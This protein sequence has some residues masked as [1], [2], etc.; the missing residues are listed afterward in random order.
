MDFRKNPSAEFK[1][2]AK[3]S[4][5]E[6]REEIEALRDGIEYH[7]YL[8]YVKN[9]P[10]ISD[11][12]YDRLLQRL[13]ELEEAYPE[14]QTD[15]SPTRRV[16]AKPLSRLTMVRH[17]APML[18]LNAVR[19]EKEV[20]DFLDF[21]EQ[22]S[23][24]RVTYVAEPKFD[25]VSVEVV[26]ENGV[27]RYGTTRGDGDTGED[28]SAN[29]RTIHSVPLRLQRIDGLPRMLAVRGEVFMLKKGF[30]DLNR[31][32]LEKGEEPFANP[33]NATAGLLRQLNPRM[34][35][36]RPLDVRF[37]DVLRSEGYEASSHW[38]TLQ[39]FG[40]WGLKVDPQSGR[41]ASFADIRSCYQKLIEKRDE[42]DYEIDGMVIK[43]DDFKLRNK[44]GTRQRSPRWALAWKFPPR[45]EISRVENII[46]Q[47]GRTGIL[48]PVAF[49]EPVDVAG[50]TISRATLHNEAEIHRKDIRKGDRV[51]VARAGDVIPEVVERI[52]EPGKKRG[53][54]F[55]MPSHCPACGTIVRKEGAFYRCPAGLSCPAQLVGHIVHYASREAMNIEGL[56]EK[57]ARQLVG[58]GLV[59]DISDLYRLSVGDL[60]AL[61]G[62]AQKSASKLYNAIQ[63][64][65][66]AR[67][68]RFIYALGIRHVGQHLAQVLA[69]NFRTL[70]ALQKADR[71]KLN[72]ILE[73]GPE[74]AASIDDFFK[75][76]R[77]RE[78]L[79]RLADAGLK[80]EDV[81]KREGKM[82][83]EGKVF[84]FTG[85]LN[86][87][88]RSEASQLVQSLGG[89]V[90]ENVGR[91]TDFIVI[92]TD[93][94]TK[95]DAARKQ[96]VS[97][98]DEKAFEL[99]LEEYRSTQ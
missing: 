32:L 19:D 43:V 66:N 45:E 44:L 18:S 41:C 57:T 31:A 28:I 36:G 17:Q 50:V 23:G 95:L 21:V 92:G 71:Y 3:M 47:V 9:Q 56:S 35:A 48:T 61:E 15:D 80:I 99:M 70:D 25:G 91:E 51:R 33:R 42:L 4:K 74:T 46:V 26:Y 96:G 88:S 54:Q 53:K 75:Q 34:V 69:K 11:A 10:A 5:E 29:L 12:I 39:R 13:Q 7:N 93:P 40:R 14:F 79:K 82:P 1:D 73:V 64:S 76:D 24:D 84:V 68:D 60:L 85:K 67:L 2:I 30:Q 38:N 86:N 16:G 37:Y 87:Y 58:K 77:N 65:K 97:I 8:Y 89:R 55:T 72:K 20:R 62:F 59:R 27:F 22:D 49:L 63:S 83:L 52:E 78:V 94:G 6:A 98:M 81:L 90:A